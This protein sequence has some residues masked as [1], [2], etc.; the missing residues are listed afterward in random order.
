MHSCGTALYDILITFPLVLT[1]L[2]IS[3]M[4]KNAGNN[5]VA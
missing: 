1:L 3:D 5:F 2:F 4:P